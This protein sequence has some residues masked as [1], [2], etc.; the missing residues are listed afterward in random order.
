[1]N[2][3]RRVDG[4][5][6]LTS[7]SYFFSSSTITLED[8]LS[9]SLGGDDFSAF[10]SS[11]ILDLALLSDLSLMSLIYSFNLSI[12]SFNCLFYLN[13]FRF[14]Y[15]EKDL[16]AHTVSL[17]ELSFSRLLSPCVLD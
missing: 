1:M 4:Y 8:F 12:S 11:S 10:T 6:L 14:F 16:R 5:S 7:Y 15:S 3:P 9:S 17:L 2:L 13:K